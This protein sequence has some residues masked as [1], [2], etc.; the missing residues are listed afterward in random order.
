M[1]NRTE[2][3]KIEFFIFVNYLFI[4]SNQTLKFEL[5][6]T[7]QWKSYDTCEQTGKYNYKYYKI[8]RRT[9]KTIWWKEMYEDGSDYTFSNCKQYKTEGRSRI[10]HIWGMFP[11]EEIS[12]NQGLS[13]SNDLTPS[14]PHHYCPFIMCKCKENLGWYNCKCCKNTIKEKIA[15]NRYKEQQKKKYPRP[16]R[17]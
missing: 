2:K 11:S 5:N 16:N 13:S 15:K 12:I 6:K 4:M 3:K 1:T 17:N 9:D 8:T 7:Y 10:K 14:E